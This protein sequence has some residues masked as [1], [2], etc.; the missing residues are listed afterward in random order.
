MKSSQEWLRIN[1]FFHKLYFLINYETIS[2]VNLFTPL[3]IRLRMQ[4][5]VLHGETELFPWKWQPHSH[6]SLEVRNPIM[7]ASFILLYCLVF[8]PTLFEWLSG[9]IIINSLWWGN[10]FYFK[11]TYKGV[12]KKLHLRIGFLYWYHW[13]VWIKLNPVKIK[14]L[15]KQS[16]QISILFCYRLSLLNLIF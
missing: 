16:T 14:E 5:S 12:F 9:S 1:K 13:F 10:Y 6:A 4:C 15:K 3:N 8:F 11:Y 7:K 2:G